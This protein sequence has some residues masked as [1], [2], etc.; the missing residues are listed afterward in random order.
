MD[1]VEDALVI[2]VVDFPFS[3][4]KVLAPG[5]IGDFDLHHEL[6]GLEIEGYR[7]RMVA[8]QMVLTEPVVIDK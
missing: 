7:E 8:A 5:I 6:V 3:E 4:R 1:L 2:R